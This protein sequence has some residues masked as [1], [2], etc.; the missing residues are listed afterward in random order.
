MAFVVRAGQIASVQV[1]P[2]P[3]AY[4]FG[5][6]LRGVQLSNKLTLTYEQIWRTQ[7]AVRTV[8]GFIARNLAQIGTK[9]IRQMDEQHVESADDH[10]L[11]ELLQIPR[12]G[13]KLTNYRLLNDL[14]NDLCVY[15]NAYWL[16]IRPDSGP[17]AGLIRVPPSMVTPHAKPWYENDSYVIIGNSG[18]PL[19]VPAENMVH[20]HGYNPHPFDRLGVQGVQGVSPMETLRGILAEE[21]AAQNYREQL[22]QR[23]ARTSGVIQ[24]PPQPS[25]KRW[26]DSDR[27]RFKREWR[28]AYSGE[29]ANAGGTPVLEDG[30]TWVPS[31]MT[32]K[33]AQYVES[34]Q[35]THQE[36]ASAYYLPQG[37]VG[38]IEDNTLSNLAD[39]RGQLYQDGLSPWAEQVAQDIACQLLPDLEPDPKLQR[40]IRVFFDFARKLHGTPDQ[41]L[42][43]M[44]TATGRPILTGN[45][46]R[47]W[48]GK[49]PVEDDPTM[50]EVVK[51]MNVTTGL[52]DN[53][54]GI[55]SPHDTAP[56]NPD[57]TASNDPQQQ[58]PDAAK[59]RV[60][61]GKADAPSAGRSAI[62]SASTSHVET[63]LR[64]YYA[65]M[66]REVMRSARR[67]LDGE[68]GPKNRRGTDY[69]SKD[70]AENL[71]VTKPINID[72][73]F[74][75]SMWDDQLAEDMLDAATAASTEAAKGL[76]SDWGYPTDD[77]DVSR[78]QNWLKVHAQALAVSMN[79][80][81]QED[82][83][84]DIEQDDPLGALDNRFNTYRD[85]RA[86][87]AA[88][89][90][91]KALI[92]FGAREAAQQYGFYETMTKTW[93]TGPKPRESHARMDGE[94]V[95]MGDVFSNGARWPGDSM[96]PPDERAGCNCT[97]YVNDTSTP[98]QELSG[99]S[100]AAGPE[101]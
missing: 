31:A 74:D 13:S 34:R 81:T 78:A 47:A 41:E 86:A 97:L 23:S 67:I 15:D 85:N 43:A 92:G 80:K 101:L 2:M 30:M 76:L 3:S 48:I 87:E 68:S 63:A 58:K 75:R 5:G 16:K 6:G 84:M 20:F 14:F 96:L 66:R 60:V 72:Q 8:C 70:G 89:T 39:K 50:D 44:S 21:Y 35:L 65:R 98:D 10:P 61:S 64:D 27:E 91:T 77:Y 51:P 90:E 99:L 53:G 42:A 57:N 19:V 73:I 69:S 36:V 95:P 54:N 29:G 4:L 12:A 94:T 40:Q 25:G 56:D 62:P 93:Q 46:G 82:L 28:E 26:A 32:P 7:P 11:A 88:G 9:V 37:I 17:L 49:P 1:A 52:R 38:L 33:D 24:R 45:E 55:A 79:A 18:S 71:S 59:G 22:W 83:E 100:G